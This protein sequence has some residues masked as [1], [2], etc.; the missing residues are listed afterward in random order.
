[1]HR[2]GKSHTSKDRTCKDTNRN[3]ELARA[4]PQVQRASM[5]RR[6]GRVWRAVAATRALRLWL[7]AALLAVR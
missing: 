3:T 6:R 2:G 4:G 1:M 5:E 7:G